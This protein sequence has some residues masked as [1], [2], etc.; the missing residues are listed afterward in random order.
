MLYKIEREIRACNKC[1]KLREVT[2]MVMPHIYYNGNLNKLK[3]FVVARNPGL[4]NDTSKIHFDDFMEY[5]KKAWW[6]CKLGKYLR[7]NLG[8]NIVKE[9]MFFTNVCK[10][11]SPNNRALDK[12][13]ISNCCN[14]LIRQLRSIN[15]EI[16]ITLGKEATD[17]FY[18][19]DCVSNT[20][21]KYC[22]FYH[23]SYFI[24]N[25]DK[26]IIAKE[27]EKFEKVI[28]WLEEKK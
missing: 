9:K 3:L 27:K 8:D 15:P 26:K 23:P 21:I 7:K 19:V 12:E 17:V 28:K 6:E 16:I 5:Y 18:L 22:S 20:E 14:F 11:S 25:N 2:P 24:Y 1:S 10:C 4:E 13:E